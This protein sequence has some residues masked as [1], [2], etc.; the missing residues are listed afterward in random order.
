MAHAFAKECL[1]AHLRGRLR[2]SKAE[3][4]LGDVTTLLIEWSQ[5]DTAARER[6]IPLVYRQLRALAGK[7]LQLEPSEVTL[8]PTALVHELYEKLVDRNRVVWQ[9]R[10][11]FFAIAAVLMRR[12]LVDHARRR[13]AQ[14]RGG[15]VTRVTLTEGENGVVAGAQVDLLALDGALSELAAV[16]PD[17]A[18]IVEMRFFGGLT[19]DETAEVL[20]I[21]RATVTREWS[22]A[23][24]F[25][26]RR[27]A[28]A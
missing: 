18:R 28:A 4:R 23:R 12:M 7:A 27:L 20:G 19:G 13:R 17:Q 26:R 6:L 3:A 2:P 5:G 11:H 14:R 10:A 8:Q 9:N 22:M 1:D 21:S 24:V 16:D 15:D 25:L